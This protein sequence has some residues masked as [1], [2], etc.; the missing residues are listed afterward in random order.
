MFSKLTTPIVAAVLAFC[1]VGAQA[2]STFEITGFTYGSEGMSINRSS[3]AYP[4]WLS[5]DAGAVTANYNGM[6]FATYCIDVYQ[7]ASIGTIYTDY[8]PKAA[9]AQFTGT[10]ANDLGRLFT[11]YGSVVDTKIESAAMQLAVW[12]IVD[13]TR[14]SYNVSNGS[15]SASLDRGSDAAVVSLANSWLSNLGSNNVYSVSALSSA[16]HQDFLVLAPVPEPSTYALM[17]AGLMGVAF[18]ARRRKNGAG[19]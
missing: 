3:S 5:V 6:S 11:S 2:A 8:T 17:L 12:E 19:N 10:Q 4:G 13:E 15:F 14:G 1:A 16:S 9:S 7:T 18:V